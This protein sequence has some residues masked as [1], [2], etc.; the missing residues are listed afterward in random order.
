MCAACSSGGACT[1]D[2]SMPLLSARVCQIVS[3]LAVPCPMDSA[4]CAHMYS[5][6]LAMYSCTHCKS[7]QSLSQRAD[8]IGLSACSSISI[9]FV[10]DSRMHGLAL[11]SSADHSAAADVGNVC[12]SA[13]WCIW[14]QLN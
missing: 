9:G 2:C 7:R 1:A 4:G 12:I 11:N 5:P 10:H 8:Q 13:E 6:M 3:I 14:C